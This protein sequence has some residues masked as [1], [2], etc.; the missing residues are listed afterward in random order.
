MWSKRTKGPKAGKAVVGDSDWT[1]GPRK[2]RA[3]DDDAP[4]SDDDRNNDLAD[5]ELLGDE[6]A[7]LP[8]A[9]GGDDE[10]YGEGL[11]LVVGG[12]GDSDSDAEE[13]ARRID[14]RTPE[15]R[16]ASFQRHLEKRRE[17]KRRKADRRA[18]RDSGKAGKGVSVR[19]APRPIKP[20]VGVVPGAE[21]GEG[22]DEEEEGG[23][24]DYEAEYA[25]GEEGEDAEAA[26]PGKAKRTRRGGKKLKVKGTPRPK[27]KVEGDGAGDG[28]GDEG[29]Q[30][31]DEETTAAAAGGG[32]TKGEVAPSVLK[33][34]KL[35][36]TPKGLVL[37][38][39]EEVKATKNKWRELKA[40]AKKD[41][42]EVIPETGSDEETRPGTHNIVVDDE[43]DND[44]DDFGG[45]EFLKGDKAYTGLPKIP[46]KT[47]TATPP[48]KKETTKAP[49]KEEDGDES[50]ENSTTEK[51]EA[52]QEDEKP[53]RRERHYLGKGK[54]AKLRKQ[55]EKLK[56][57]GV[58]ADTNKEV[59]TGWEWA[60]VEA[61]GE[62]QETEFE[63]RAHKTVEKQAKVQSESKKELLS[64]ESRED[65]FHFPP[66]REIESTDLPAIFE[67]IHEVT[68]VLSNFREERDP[69]RSRQDYIRLLE[70][71]LS[72]YYATSKFV[73]NKL[74][75]LFPVTE[76]LQIMAANEQPRPVTLRVNTLKTRRRDLAQTLIS[77]GVNLDPITWSKIGLIVYDSQVPI[78]ATPEY[79]AGHY[80]LQSAASFLP[81]VA[82]DPQPGEYILDACAA[83]GGKTTHIAAMMKNTGILLANDVNAERCKALVANLHRMGVQN[84]FVSCEDG[85]LL[86]KRI[87]GFNRILLDA[88]CTGLGVIS[89]DPSIKL[90]KSAKDIYE[91][92]K[93]QKELI[94]AVIDS[95]KC[96]PGKPGI[97]V[98]STCSITVE[99]NENIVNYALRKRDVRIVP[100]GLP[101]GTPG[102]TKWTDKRFHPSTK[103]SMRYYPHTHNLDGFFVCKLEKISD[104]V[105]TKEGDAKRVG[106]FRE[107]DRVKR[108]AQAERQ[109]TEQSKSPRALAARAKARQDQLR[110]ILANEAR[111]KQ[112]QRQQQQE[113]AR[114]RSTEQQQQQPE[115]QANLAATQQPPNTPTE[116]AT[117]KR[118]P[119]APAHSAP[120]TNNPKRRRT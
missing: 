59:G 72:F 53:R 89:R 66:K 17:A 42:F 84:S 20:V 27:D 10:G 71:D 55:A 87:H 79:M 116:T 64:A 8:A 100:T 108:L 58:Q 40:R 74:M 33:A 98:Y 88:P 86:A 105:K 117:G 118:P 102:F 39:E 67:R 34:P 62:E 82:L 60:G 97:L 13:A 111:R 24:S 95:L 5:L 25:K 7:A 110:Q 35:R 44:D 65:R 6:G 57:E 93:V 36:V 9:R 85:R 32:A 29:E 61:N 69:K 48:V 49:V 50:G 37:V 92:C 96:A 21:A 52:T 90:S 4:A 18:A 3:D 26:K 1:S 68:K 76:V 23:G 78:G 120:A 107:E 113:A 103:L 15:E 73:V 43:D 41:D 30:E 119:N 109:R 28:E 12:G 54:R 114:S 70:H 16:E 45:D 75:S 63:K 38:D 31:E 46:T 83:P 47:V 11:G 19:V 112:M 99:E 106:V 101:F 81:V 94:L 22:E 115:Q 104:L 77:R 80:M 14:H 2:K 51:P 91:C 56:K